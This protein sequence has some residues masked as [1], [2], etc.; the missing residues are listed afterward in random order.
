MA[1][2]LFTISMAWETFL[3]SHTHTHTHTHIHINT[4]THTHTHTQRK[5]QRGKLRTTHTFIARHTTPSPTH[6]IIA[7]S[8]AEAQA[9]FISV[10]VS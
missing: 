5:D 9:F 8:T 2:L 6:L 3:H 1:I 7:A 10:E 4:H